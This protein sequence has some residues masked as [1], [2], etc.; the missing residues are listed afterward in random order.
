MS[1]SVSF[2]GVS[3]HR[4]TQHLSRRRV[5][6]TLLAVLL[7]T[8]VAPIPVTLIALRLPSEGLPVLGPFTEL[9]LSLAAIG[10]ILPVTLLI[11]RVGERRGVGTLSSV[12]GRLRWRW[13]A[14]CLLIA[15]TCI[16]VALCLGLLT[17]AFVKA[18]AGAS[19]GGSEPQTSTWI[20]IGP[21][22]TVLQFMMALTAV[23][24]AAEETVC[25]GVILQAVGRLF[26]SPWPA[27]GVQAVIFTALHGFGGGWWGQLGVL[28]FG[29]AL[30]WLT[31]RTGGLEAALAFHFVQNGLV[32]VVAVAAGATDP[33]ANATAAPWPLAV[34]IAATVGT[35]AVAT[36]LA[37]RLCGIT[38]PRPTPGDL[39]QTTSPSPASTN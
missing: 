33:N 28:A 13:L 37:A 25:R 31:V 20:G 19:G 24:V 8:V 14:L 12:V 5:L 30:G 16:G 10:C 23:Q 11:V 26:R 35:Y 27:I 18:S 38:P 21:A 15:G 3:Y 9:V 39:D 29:V 6:V 1:S 36:S 32:A 22:L 4:I 34:A 7:G 2:A 17:A